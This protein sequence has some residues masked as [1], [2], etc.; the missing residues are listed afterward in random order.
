MTENE[1][2]IVAILVVR[3]LVN[4][5]FH[6]NTLISIFLAV[7]HETDFVID[8]NFSHQ[9]HNQRSLRTRN[10]PRRNRHESGACKADQ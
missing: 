2:I 9:V 4:L 5:L 3:F 1:M 7:I 8:L 10:I 6:A